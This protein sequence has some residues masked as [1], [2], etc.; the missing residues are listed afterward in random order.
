M[1]KEVL[2]PLRVDATESDGSS[3]TETACVL[4]LGPRR[5]G[6][7]RPRVARSAAVGRQLRRRRMPRRLPIGRDAVEAG[8]PPPLGVPVSSCAGLPVCG[9]VLGSPDAGSRYS[10]RT[11]LPAPTARRARLRHPDSNAACGQCIR[12]CTEQAAARAVHLPHPTSPPPR[13]SS[14]GR[15]I[16]PP[17]V[18]AGHARRGHRLRRRRPGTDDGD[19]GRGT[20]GASPDAGSRYGRA[21]GRGPTQATAAERGR[22]CARSPVSAEHERLLYPR[23]IRG[24]GPP[25]LRRRC[26]RAGAGRWPA[27]SRRSERRARAA[28]G[29]GW[30]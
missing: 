26:P 15:R 21:M 20:D 7:F 3:L 24:R 19:P 9:G 2:S 16:P 12:S 10:H 4:A 29:S 5:P 13:A 22:R 17:A 8:P 25:R 18:D 6:V 27:C 1:T 23:R 11:C 14:A 30:P 28:R